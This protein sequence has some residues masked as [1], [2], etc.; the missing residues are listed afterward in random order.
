WPP[1]W[2]G[3]TWSAPRPV[4]WPPCGTTADSWR[5]RRAGW[6]SCC[7]RSPPRSSRTSPAISRGWGASFPRLGRRISRGVAVA[8][9]PQVGQVL[10]VR[11]LRVATQLSGNPVE[12]VWR[13]HCS[14]YSDRG[15]TIG[16]RSTACDWRSGQAYFDTNRTIRETFGGAGFPPNGRSSCAPTASGRQAPYGRPARDAY[17][18]HEETRHADP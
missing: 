17:P 16:M 3:P 1:I 5:T 11:A 4:S 15:G 9:L 2:R 10:L 18:A 6:L 7:P 12:R 14:A 13:S 8:D